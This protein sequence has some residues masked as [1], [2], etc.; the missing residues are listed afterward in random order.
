MQCE[1]ISYKFGAYY[2]D[3]L[4]EEKPDDCH[5]CLKFIQSHLHNHNI[6]ENKYK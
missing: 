4:N 3:I 2:C 1:N 6:N 5:E